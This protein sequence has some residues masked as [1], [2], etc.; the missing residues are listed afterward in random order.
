MKLEENSED[1]LQAAKDWMNEN[2]ELVDSWLPE[3]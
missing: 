2:E 3:N 1:K